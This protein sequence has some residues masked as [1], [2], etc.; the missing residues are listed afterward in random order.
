MKHLLHASR[1]F[2]E[3]LFTRLG[4]GMRAK[5][6]SLFV[7]IKV[8]PL[9]LLALVAWRQSWLLG[10]ELGRRT[11]ELT[12]KANAALSKTGDIAVTD[13]VRAL[14]DRATDDI[15]RMT[16]DAARRVADFLYGRDDDIRFAA[17]M[18]P[19]AGVFRNF[20]SSHNRYLI[21]QSTWELAPNGKSWQLA[22]QPAPGRRIAS[23][24]KEND[25]SFNY[26]APD[27]F[28]RESRPLY[29]EMTFVDP[30][31]Q[32]R[33]KVTTSPRMDSALKNVAD[34]KNTYAKAET[35]FR[36]LKK[37]KPGEIYV[38]DVIGTYVPSRVIG[39]Y[40]PENAA[41]RGL[42]FEPEKEAYAGKENPLGRRFQ[43]IVRWAMP[44]VEN[45]TITGYV[46]LALDH[47]HIMEFTAHIMPTKERYTE[48]P[49]AYEGNYAFIWDHRGRSIVHPRHYSI[50]GFNPETG[51]PQVPWL[52]DRIYDA[53]QKSGES[54]VDFIADEPT[55]VGQS[56]KKKPAPA[57]TKQGL[58]G[59]D[60]RYLNFAPQCTGWFDLTQDGGSGSF[61][62]LWSGLKK[63]TTAAA[64]PYYTGQYAASKRGFG[65]VTIGAGL[66][67][68]HRPATETKGVIDRLI[69]ESDRELSR[70]AG[71][72][73]EAIG[74]NLLET[75]TS[76]SVS[77]GVMAVLVVLIAIW[78]ASVFT[79]SITTLIN[80]I[81]RFRAGERHF[82][83]NSPIKDELGTLADSFDE[84]ADSLVDSTKAGPIVITDNN[85]NVLYM[86]EYSLRNL[87]KT[88]PEVLGKPYPENS[89]YPAGSKY[90]PL[91][92]LHEGREAEVLFHERT[93]RYFQG[94]ADY[95][96]NKAGD[97]IGYAISTT[98]VTELIAEQKRIE[99]QRAL[100]D[101]T[102]SSSPDLIW[103][104]D[105]D[106]RFLTVNPRFAA[107]TGRQPEELTGLTIR[108]VLPESVATPFEKNDAAAVESGMP[109]YTEEQ[110]SFADRHTEI[111]D[112]VRT[113]IYNAQGE[114]VGLLGVSR[115]VSRRVSIESELRQTQLELKKAVAAANMANESK[116]EFLARMSHEI[117]T[118][119]NAIIGMTN[120]TK[121]KLSEP[122]AD[123][124]EILSHIRQLE[125]SSKHLLG[126]L[127][128][129]LDISKIEAG[130][131]EL[132]EEVF[133]MAK[134]TG[135]VAS[136]IRPRCLEKNIAFDV[137]MDD[138]APDT[139]ISDP[140]RLRQVLINLLG[141]AV[142]FTPECG[143]VEFRAMRKER[144]DGKTLVAFR[145]TDSGIGIS[146][147][148][149]A[150]LFVPF[151][152]GGGQIA[153]Q[154]GGTGLGLSISRRI[155]Q[156]LGGDIE[157]SSREGEGSVFGFSVWLTE[158]EG[159]AARETAVNDISA[160]RGKR[161][162]LVD[163]VDINRII[164][165]DLLSSTGL[166]IDEAEDGRV[167]VDKF[168]ASPS[169]YYDIIFM[170]VQMPHM[171]GYQA[172][173]AIR[174]LNRPDAATV[175]IIA[176]TANAFKEDV[177]KAI[178][179]G[180]NAHLPKPLEYERL[181]ELTVRFVGRG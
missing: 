174:G 73:R 141:N 30:N 159:N 54:Y 72:T 138:F 85:K 142:K 158:A 117:R 15:E 34:R 1:L 172:S 144:R 45:D 23:S 63:L 154:Y 9:I 171:D 129:I 136:I 157:V 16:T 39:M 18:K 175:P 32:E 128:D 8:V 60:C 94:R 112:S 124:A 37:L 20:L 101:T 134:L 165:I 120:I 76:L 31:G 12:Q 115:D 133:E 106:G 36:E 62:I 162:L 121:R 151:E 102:F 2:I 135:A 149:L 91:A 41:K 90:C 139:F 49:D 153:R 99:Q 108:D 61:V 43:G 167:A 13:A 64:I 173:R 179:H 109:L 96:R 3:R 69:A 33:I 74:K 104:Q 103:Y 27:P 161:V 178:A 98:D 21:K 19:S 56:V 57:L 140:L 143:H 4:L 155:V 127:N 46:T 148:M 114:L 111:L 88:L 52:E 55:F 164:V 105:K 48:I 86:N 58:V 44:V 40:T 132:A 7:V 145:V 67:D 87:D 81:S 22:E 97:P 10:E 29:L 83:F 35:Y 170:D 181:L 89:I 17:A 47:D 160:L 156:L 147:H 95:L 163:D 168:A 70:S 84:M 166:A 50:T 66:D 24:I 68:F 6:I 38:S 152:Q 77:T 137:V 123:P 79:R 80:G 113:P 71:E 146:E 107:V 150:N 75:A 65:F 26:R 82:R 119:M 25:L 126:L 51:D 131:I 122:G 11:E 53:W 180:M 176:M 130:K 59:L 93:G 78:M 118:P 100:L 42:P 28:V 14:D 92:A 116:S 177:D 5:L 125:I 110:I 169:G